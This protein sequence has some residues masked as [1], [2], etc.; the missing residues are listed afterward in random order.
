MS[1][2][3][4]EVTRETLLPGINLIE[5]N[6]GTGKTY[7]IAMLYLR[8]IVEHGFLIDQLL[9]VTFTHAAATELKERI[10]LKLTEIYHCLVADKSGLDE[11]TSQW[12]Q[13]LE[14][15][16]ALV[17]QRLKAALLD[18]DQSA[19]FTI[20]GFCYKTLQ[21]FS[22]ESKQLFELNLVGDSQF[23]RRQLSDDFWR[24]TIYP[25]RPSEAA[26]LSA[27]YEDPATL[28]VSINSIKGR[29][30]VYPES[31]TLTKCLGQVSAAKD[32][33]ESEFNLYIQ[34]LSE[35]VE[36]PFFKK[37]FQAKFFSHQQS[38]QQ[39]LAMEQ[40]TFPLEALKSFSYQG[41]LAGLNGQK[42]RAKNNQTGE[43][44]KSDYLAD[45]GLH[46]E[47]I[48][49]V[50]EASESACL[51]LRSLLLA[52][53]RNKE[54]AVLD[55]SQSVSF[56]CL[57]SRLADLMIQTDGVELKEALQK[58]YQVALI[59]EFQD[60][61]Q[62]QWTIFSQLFAQQHHFLYL[63][64]DPKQAIYKFRGA[65]VFSYLHA[66][67]LAHRQYTL[68]DNWRSNPSMVGAINTLFENQKNV[69]LLEGLNYQPC[70]AVVSEEANYL[71]SGGRCLSGMMLWQ[72]E[73]NENN[74]SSFL[75]STNAQLQISIAVVNEII[76]L[77][78][79]SNGVK[80]SIGGRVSTLSAKDIAILVRSNAQAVAYQ[81]L[82]REVGIPSVMNSAKSVFETTE[83]DD[84]YS[85][86]QAITQ[87]S[88]LGLLKQFL[89]V[90][91]FN[92]S[93]TKLISIVEND[94]LLEQWSVRLSEYYVLWEKKG[95]LAMT[96]KLLE[97]EEVA[98]KLSSFPAFE[99]KM[100]NI[101]Q[102]AEL[103]QVAETENN[104][105]INGTLDWF[106]RSVA[107]LKY[108]ESELLRLESDQQGIN[109]LTVHRS[110]GLE[111][112]IVFCPVL[113]QQDQHIQKE[114][115]VTQCHEDGLM[116]ADLGTKKF[117]D[118]KK[119]AMQ[120][121]FAED[122]RLSYVAMTRAK[123]RCYIAWANVRT[124]DKS[125]QSALSWLLFNMSANNDFTQQQS[126]LKSRVSQYNSFFEYQLLQED[127]SLCQLRSINKKPLLKSPTKRLRDLKTLWQINSYTGLAALSVE[128]VYEGRQS[129]WEDES[130]VDS[131]I[132]VV[133]QLP[134][135]SR[136][137]NV[138]HDLLEKNEFIDLAQHGDILF[139]VE[140]AC[141]RF[142]LKFDHPALIADL[143]QQVVKTPLTG[144][145]DDFCLAEI[146]NQS[147][148]KE[149]PFYLSHAQIN[150]EQINS[151]LG[152]ELNYK[153][154]TSKSLTGYL[155]G[156][157][158]L[159]CFHQGKYYLIDYKSNYLNDY[160]SVELIGAMRAHNYG[161]QAWLYS[162]VLTNF[163]QETV[164]EY[165][166]SNHFGGVLYLF[167]RGMDSGRPGSGVYSF[168]P[169]ADQLQ[170]LGRLLVDG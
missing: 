55:E 48:E 155:T 46:F 22:I 121:S 137:G 136:F 131:E 6:A 95:V 94:E 59:D 92:M 106:Q 164:H 16:E 43:E 160:N 102:L 109:I 146:D 117:E 45:L 114:N 112:S 79:P 111:F 73:H 40:L 107:D 8:F 70:Q 158:D 165:S 119:I 15:E 80:Q 97:S 34:V 144:A 81:N 36:L 39:W 123:F 58:R 33:L 17:L 127:Q 151:I 110:K 66:A 124:K 60:T 27:Y 129:S 169:D 153:P 71:K 87:P 86:L 7:T 157:I 132:H 99:R 156:F 13:D 57:I 32:D 53:I 115:S 154:L 139:K 26:V 118:R 152:N 159:V 77:L 9:V 72:L 168:L 91:W 37:T 61:D 54:D 93:A 143:L 4:F 44:R 75:K 18:L 11:V 126:D 28:L 125:N 104:F 116:V 64:G 47:A 68:T 63:V 83:A 65:D 52:Y 76:D 78:T 163:L 134:R 49:K 50:I 62:M 138:I 2:T 38:I 161:L 141:A 113:W 51:T 142:G 166:Y 103:L 108:S 148:I 1:K 12:L 162:L 29:V 56:D 128:E 23:L 5:A 25:L 133:D 31:Q 74:N 101:L 82:L 19:I 130:I 105:N 149:M 120:E 135:G 69:F 67:K 100:S 90:A 24:Q 84:F 145:S 14:L 150:T 35:A 42:F 122:I 3:R 98:S 85:I 147:C 140:Q 96:Y 170:H 89:T 88:N 10:R 30:T 41:V 20:H 21:E 167:V